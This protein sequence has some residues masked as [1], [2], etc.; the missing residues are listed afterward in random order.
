MEFSLQIWYD[1]SIDPVLPVKSGK[2]DENITKKDGVKMKMT[3]VKSN[4]IS[5]TIYV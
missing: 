3:F 2:R 5:P 1:Y 4:Q